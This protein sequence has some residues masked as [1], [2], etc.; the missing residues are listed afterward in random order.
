MKRQ[1]G[2]I[3]GGAAGLT[4]A[5]GAARA[6]ARVIVME[7]MDRVGRK[8]L[9]TGNGRCNLTNLRMEASCYRCGQKGFPMEVIAGFPVEETLAFF[10]R[11]GIEPK[12]RNGYIYPNSDQA[13]SV[14]DALR[15]EAEYQGVEFR[16]SCQV[17]AIRRRE[18]GFGIE[19]DQGRVKADAVILAPGSKAAPAT[20]SDGSG[21]PL[22]EQLGHHVIKPLPALVQLRCQGSLYRQTAGVR[23]EALVR[24]LADGRELAAD[25]GELQLTDYGISGIPVFQVSRYAARALD[26]GR[27]VTARIDF[28]PSWGEE[29]AFR[30]LRRRASLLGYRPAGELLTG[31]LN[32]KLGAALLKLAGVDARLDSGALSGR[33]LGRILEQVKKYEALVMSV[34]PFENAQV[35]CGGVDTSEV[36][37]RTME[38]RIC[39]GLYLAG[40]ILDVDGICGGYNLQFA[41][42]SGM[43]AGRQAAEGPRS[44]IKE[45]NQ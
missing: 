9:S 42:S 3:G 19:T 7:H 26:E 20:G 21:Y 34:N 8:L 32:R 43:T 11:L 27:R 22:A 37:P 39:P 2:I 35:C 24:L 33:Q 10:Q 1:I 14:L 44:E 30:L 4:A 5:I 41:W 12:N 31:M 15:W 6:G 28:M 25:Q 17:K 23:T 16:L 18:K 40:E 45:Q 36:D 13:S 29:E 38:S